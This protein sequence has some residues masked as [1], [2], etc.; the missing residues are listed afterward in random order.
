ML[1]LFERY[2]HKITSDDW[3]LPE[4]QFYKSESGCKF[5]DEYSFARR[6]VEGQ[7]SKKPKKD[8]DISA[9]AI[10]K[11]AP[12]LGCVFQGRWNLHRFYGRAQKSWDQFDERNSQKLRCVTQTSEKPK[13]RRSE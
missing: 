2:L 10:L 6:Q 8:G 1:R 4:C 3:H 12:Q 5:G 13:V 9:V 7:P 11:D